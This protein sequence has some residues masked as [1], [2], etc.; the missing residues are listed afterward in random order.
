V[1]FVKFIKKGVVLKGV[2][3]CNKGLE[4]SIVNSELFL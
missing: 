3:F 2:L 1:K 4:K